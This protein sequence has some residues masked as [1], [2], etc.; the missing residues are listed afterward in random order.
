MLRR[1]ARPL[2]ALACTVSLSACSSPEPTPPPGP[3]TYD[4]PWEVL[5]ERGEW[6]DPGPFEACTALNAQAACGAPETFTVAGCD[7]SSLAGLERQGAI[8]RAE[9]RYELPVDGGGTRAAPGSGGFQFDATG[10]PTSIM[11]LAPSASSVEGGRFVL[12]AEHTRTPNETNRYIFAGCQAQGPQRFTGCFTWCRNGTPRYRGSFRA[13][14][15]TWRQDEPEASGLALLSES[16]VDRGTPVDVYV[17]HGHAYVVSINAAGNP[18]GLTVF[19][20]RTPRAPV[21][22]ASFQLPSDGYWNGVWA[23]DNALY[24]ASGDAGVLVFDL[25]RPARPVFVR[26]LPAASGPINVH[27]VFV[28]GTRLYAMSPAPDQETLIFDVANAMEPRLLARYAYRDSGA[29]GYPHDAF[30]YDGRLYINHMTD[31]F[32]VVGLEGETPA[33]LGRYAHAYN[34]SHA[35]AVGTFQGRTVAFE[36]GETLGA[37]VRVLDVTNPSGIVKV[38]EYKLRGLTSVHNMV[39]VGTRLYVAHYHEGVRVLDVSNPAQP[40]ELAH[41][42]TFRET[43]PRRTDGMFEGAIGMRVP[44]DGQVYVVDTARGLL[45]FD[46]PAP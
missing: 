35:N 29:T 24:I 27:T 36:G 21:Q 4:G 30:A 10:R 14:R 1:A 39:L 34:V 45:I 33:L 37:H 2:L 23:K 25:E 20:V 41:F 8:Y 43:D 12:S 32:L 3:S 9:I 44:G 18:G 26:N 42:N 16:F 28:E 5:P 40:R 31:G 22:T 15:M 11:G 17:T 13:E 38:G 46:T 7:M 6:V 19:D